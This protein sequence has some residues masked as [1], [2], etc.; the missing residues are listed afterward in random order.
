MIIRFM[1]PMAI[2]KTIMMSFLSILVILTRM[3]IG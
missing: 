3:K 1:M 2:M